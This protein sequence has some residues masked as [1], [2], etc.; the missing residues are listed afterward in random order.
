MRRIGVAG[1]GTLRFE[2]LRRLVLVVDMEDH[3]Y[4]DSWLEFFGAV[5]TR[6]RGIEHLTINWGL[7]GLR[8]HAQSSG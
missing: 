7:S 6:A 4:W 5:L 1:K 8:P 2:R 3:A